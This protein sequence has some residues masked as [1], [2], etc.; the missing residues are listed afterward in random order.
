LLATTIPPFLITEPTKLLIAG[1]MRGDTADTTP[2]RTRSALLRISLSLPP[3][4][5][6]F[7]KVSPDDPQ[8]GATS[9]T[10]D[11]EWSNAQARIPRTLRNVKNFEVLLLADAARV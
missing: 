8:E 3:D 9:A 10:D 7:G 6:P 5:P 11:I 1:D 4:N 2:L